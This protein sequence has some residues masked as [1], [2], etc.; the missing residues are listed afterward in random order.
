MMSNSHA[1]APSANLMA[2]VLR[3]LKPFW[4]VVFTATLLG[5]VGG[6]TTTGLLGRINQALQRGGNCPAAFG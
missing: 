5:I 4:P 1:G 6:L 3:L 2:E